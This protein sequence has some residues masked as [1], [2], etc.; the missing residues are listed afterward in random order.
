MVRYSDIIKDSV[1][2][3]DEDGTK[4]LTDPKKTDAS[5]RFSAIKEFSTS[6]ELAALPAEKDTEYMEQ[7]CSTIVDYLKKVQELV[8]NDEPF[9]IKQAVDTVTHIVNTPEL[10]EKFYQSTILSGN[11]NEDYLTYHLIKVMVYALKVGTGLKYSR[12]KLLELGLA[13]L[14]YD[15]GL[16]KMPEKITGKKGTLTDT[17]LDII[18]KHA[19]IGGDILSRFQTEHPML[20]R[21]AQEHHERENGSGYPAQLEGDDICEYAKIMGLVD[22]FDAM[23]HNRPYRKALA[24]H[25][26]VKE[27]VGSKNFLFSSKIIKAFLDEMGVFPVGSYVRL[28]NSEIGK[29]IATSKEHPLKP[30]I[31]ITF[32]GHGNK[33]P[34]ENVIKLE[35]HPILYVTTAVSEEELPS[36]QVV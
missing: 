1:K 6:S 18:K 20:P 13:A 15:I 30:T 27:L 7:L 24:Q 25:F 34:A 19:E 21:V 5:L 10:I 11:D 14:F 31:R 33:A 3:K 16:F 26:S 28:N 36:N 9:D 35:E 29:V 23:I 17:E 12:K 4:D 8:K 32:N 22:T 2:K